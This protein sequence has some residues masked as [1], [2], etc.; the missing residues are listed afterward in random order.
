MNLNS[1]AWRDLV[2][3]GKNQK[4]GAYY[5]RKTS[6][7]RHLYALAI[8]FGLTIAVILLLL[9]F[10]RPREDNE[11]PLGP[12]N[13]SEL[14]MMEDL[15]LQQQPA[16]PE[17]IKKSTPPKIVKDNEIMEPEKKISG[18]PISLEPITATDTTLITDSN[19]SK[20]SEKKTQ[21][22]ELITYILDEKNNPAQEFQSIQTMILRH[23]YQNIRYPDAAYKQR[24]KG[25][26]V[27][28][29]ILNEDGSISEITLVKGVYIFLD[30]EVLRVIKS[31]PKYEAVK[32]EG[33]AVKVKFYLPVTFS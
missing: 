31:M 4:Y 9:F 16:L 21:Q 27:Y 15:Y 32:K 2:F 12:I 26:V 5:L 11:I 18:E 23:V 1:D 25:R 14:Y 29:F 3:E 30:E 6:N 8:V 22:D 24:I 33:K 17:E 10:T 20:E 19:L 7:K 28:S 13:I